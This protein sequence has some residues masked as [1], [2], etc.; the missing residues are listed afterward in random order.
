MK[1]W[2]YILALSVLFVLLG[3][4]SFTADAQRRNRA[5]TTRYGTLTLKEKKVPVM[6][7]A[8]L[9][10]RDSLHRAD[11]LHK[12]DS[13]A[14]LGKSSLEKPAFSTAKDSIVEVFS[15]GKR[16]VY[17]YGDVNVKYQDMELTAYYME[18]DMNLGEVYAKGQYDSLT[19][20]WKGKP[21]MKQGN[22]TYNMDEVRYNFN[23]HRAR[24]KNMD[25]E[26]E[27]GTIRGKNIKMMEDQSIN[28]Q[29]GQYTVCDAEHPHYYLKLSMAKVMPDKKIIFG[30]ANL[31]VEDV[32]IPFI[33]LPFGFVPKKPE[34]ATGL[35]MPTFGEEEARG[36]YLRDLGMYF[37]I[38]DFFDISVTGDYYTLGSWAVDLN[39]RYKVNYKCNGNM[40]I[41]YS[42]D[43]TGEKGSADF[44]SSTNFGVRWSHSQDSKAHPGTTF[45][46]SVN[47]SSP[48][49]SR[50]NSHSVN[51]ALQNQASS[52]IS[53]SKNWNGKFN[54][55][56]NALHS[57]NS[58]DSSYTFTL[59]NISFQM[60]TIYPFKRK[61]RVGKE[62]AYEKISFGY[63]TSLRN[64][65]SFKAKEFDIKNPDFL[66]KFQNGMT[67]NFNIGL[68]S[69][70][71]FK[72]L[73]FSPSISYG[74]N[75]FFRTTEYE[76][77]PETQKLESHMSHQLSTLGITHTYSGSISMS[78]R[79][80]G[81]FQFG[82]RSRVQAIRHVVS[83]SIS[84]SFS[85]EKGTAFNGYR[86]LTYVDAHGKEQ[87]YEYNI[88]EKQ[89]GS[90]PGKGKSATASFSIGNNLEA[91]VRDYK[92]TTGT[93]FKKVKLI[94]QL[95]LASN[96]NFLKDSLKMGT[97]SMNMSTNLFNKVNISAS[98]AF[99]P[100]AI[101]DNG[102][103]I[104]RWAVTQGQGLLR[105]TNA[106]L[107]ASYSIS[108]KG[109][110]NGND[111]SKDAG[112]GEG[113]GNASSGGAASYYNRIYYHPVTGEYIPGGWV[114]YTNPNVPWSLNFSTSL[115][116]NRQYTK[117]SVSQLLTTKDNVTATLQAS[118][119]IKLTPRLSI[120]AST[121]FDFVAG[122]I[123]TSQV[124]ATYD[125]HCFKIDVQW[126]PT[127]MYKSYSFR[128]AANAAALADLLR[129]RKS[130]SYWDN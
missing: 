75:W 21:V 39:S 22:A 101:G 5:A 10:R 76:Y 45:S 74:Q 36:F 24:I 107:S 130:N 29:K 122:K 44:F 129:Y 87:T 7:S 95:N 66:D 61:V 19:G 43:Q 78:T 128:I 93:G 23:T 47:F 112:N 80:Y 108:G 84:M 123:T 70:Q 65:I 25:T 124:S 72:Y 114:Y 30:P 13:I 32:N 92:D 33:G 126:V 40:S 105:F 51:E 42:Y 41:N 90:L 50:Y 38:G 3:S 104:N 118:G 91:K 56:V 9:A 120:N 35:L 82:R 26:D 79:L 27:Q 62:K 31:V 67:H 125:L 48:S 6:D 100:Y 37:V 57:Q 73:N 12:I 111:G 97:V 64:Q 53:Y 102:R 8:A 60:T 88:Y 69:F 52:S 14:L 16:L 127:G 63:S 85:P 109:T 20:E 4:V 11:S 34:R 49:N 98:A 17:Y 46:A 68:P 83:P 71:L 81:M 121:G 54:M 94:D 59:P 106:S 1:R 117:D 110:I 115:Q 99:D 77:N 28:M 96:Y 116:L 18:Y 113:G 89:L 103:Q 15:D 86:T 2:L 58:R 119:N 55:S